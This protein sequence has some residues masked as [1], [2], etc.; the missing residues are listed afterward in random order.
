MVR[1]TKIT[2]VLMY[3]VVIMVSSLLGLV[4]IVGDDNNGVYSGD[5]SAISVIMMLVPMVGVM[6]MLRVCN[7]DSIGVRGGG[8]RKDHCRY[9]KS[10]CFFLAKNQIHTQKS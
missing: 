5:D 10:M 6:V 2:I 1:T 9:R 4:M 8:D 7:V 3:V